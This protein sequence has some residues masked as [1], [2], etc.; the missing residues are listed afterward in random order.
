MEE[1]LKKLFGDNALTFSQFSEALSA[2]PEIKLANLASGEYVAKSKYDAKETELN[3]ANTTI[4]NL[5]DAAK[6]FDGVD[7]EGLKN[8]ISTL[9][10]KYN[11]DIDALKLSSAVDAFIAKSGAK[12]AKLVKGC[13]DLKKV[14]LDGETVLGLTEQLDALRTSDSYLFETTNDGEN[15]NAQNGAGSSGQAGA[16]GTGMSA[17]R[18][19][20]EDLSKLSDDEYYARI[21]ENGGKK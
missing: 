14:K 13:I 16:G 19:G 7:V 12:N 4:K 9:K 21:F 1:L 20:N 5:Q 11:D 6:K 17:G 8:E 15:G 2:H 3:T 10:Q 18:S